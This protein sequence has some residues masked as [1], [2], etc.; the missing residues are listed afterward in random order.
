MQ[1]PL[2]WKLVINVLKPFNIFSGLRAAGPLGPRLVNK[3][4]SRL[5]LLVCCYSIFRQFSGSCQD[6]VKKLLASFLESCLLF[7]RK[8]PPGLQ[9]ATLGY[10]LLSYCTCLRCIYGQNKTLIY[11][12][13]SLNCNY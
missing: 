2:R 5:K 6:V 9:V 4:S 13:C 7:F 8:F 11:K 10:Y 1:I 3:V 12:Y